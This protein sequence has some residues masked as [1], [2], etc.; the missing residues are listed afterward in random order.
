MPL[1][2]E[3]MT[4]SAPGALA[5]RLGFD[6]PAATV[7]QAG[8]TQATATALVSNFSILTSGTGGVIVSQS[9]SIAAVINISGASANI[10]PPLGGSI[11]GLSANAAFAVGN[12]KQALVISAGLN[13]VVI[14]SA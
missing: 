8:T 9:H 7:V 12:N 10:Y 5:N 13:F 11:N 2:T 4:A 6:A 1:K 14:L 3:L